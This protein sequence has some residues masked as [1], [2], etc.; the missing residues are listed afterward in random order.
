MIVSRKCFETDRRRIKAG[1]ADEDL[2]CTVMMAKE[3]SL[4][5]IGVQPLNPPEIS[6]GQKHDAD[7][8]VLMGIS[9]CCTGQHPPLPRLHHCYTA[10]LAGFQSVKLRSNADEK[11]RRAFDMFH[12]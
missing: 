6:I 11:A 2:P 5:S 9:F 8:W 7:D 10:A 12:N 1:W 3:L 4:E